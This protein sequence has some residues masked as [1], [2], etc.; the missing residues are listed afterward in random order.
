VHYLPAAVKDENTMT[1]TMAM[2]NA[3][4]RTLAT[5][6]ASTIVWLERSTCPSL[7]WMG[8][9]SLLSSS[10]VIIYNP[11]YLYRWRPLINSF[12]YCYKAATTLSNVTSK[13]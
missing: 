4:D 11:M 8:S 3:N 12:I 6:L 1:M 9:C 10:R 5:F 7:S 2:K 13:I